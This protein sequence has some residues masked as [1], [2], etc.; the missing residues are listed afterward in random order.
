MERS[1]WKSPTFAIG[2]TILCFGC[3]P[4]GSGAAGPA[5]EAVTGAE[6]SP[7]AAQGRPRDPRLLPADPNTY[8]EWG[9]TWWRTTFSIPVGVDGS[10]P[11]I[12][13]GAFAGPRG[14]RFLSGVVGATATIPIDVPSGAPI[15]FPIINTECSELEPVPFAG[16]SDPSL[17]ACANSYIDHTASAF[18]EL[19]GVPI[20]GVAED[21]QAYRAPS[22]NFT[23]GPLP[24]NNVL[25]FLYGDFT[26]FYPGVTS[27]AA[28]A[29]IYL[30]LA[31]LSAG[32]HR[33]HFGAVLVGSP[34]DYFVD[35]TYVITVAP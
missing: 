26:T 31:P 16:S 28:D 21:P 4:D 17:R 11:I 33:L 10:H 5:I 24:A 8:G 32:T 6:D 3:A 27:R 13:G 2:A 35:T 15:F 22:L 19:D 14:V 20:A 18:A 30:M 34:S 29:G 1:F 7:A 23:Y 9:A 12:G 25:G